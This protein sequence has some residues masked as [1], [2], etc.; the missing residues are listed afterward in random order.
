MKPRSR[1]ILRAGLAAAG[2]ATMFLAT[3]SVA[4]AQAG[5]IE[6]LEAT[7]EA[8]ESRLATVDSLIEREDARLA[9]LAERADLAEAEEERARLERLIDRYTL[10]LDE[11]EATRHELRNM[12][13]ALREAVVALEERDAGR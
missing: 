12:L 4:V 10:A 6:Q 5:E 8:V 7:I 11:M 13:D 2:A 9:G 3:A 1:P